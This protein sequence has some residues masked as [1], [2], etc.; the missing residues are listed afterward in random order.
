MKVLV[1]GCCGFIGSHVSIKLLELN[2]NVVGVDIMNN[3]Y[4]VEIKEKNKNML[5]EY[6]N[7]SDI[8]FITLDLIR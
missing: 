8:C 2:Y 3:Y 4:D 6:S 1:T 5:T 7:F